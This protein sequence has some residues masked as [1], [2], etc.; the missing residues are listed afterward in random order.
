MIYQR[1]VLFIA[2]Q[3]ISEWSISFLNTSCGGWGVAAGPSF[4]NFC[5]KGVEKF[6]AT[7]LTKRGRRGTKEASEL[8]ANG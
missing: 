3:Q 2:F 5:K 7:V 1:V 8:T 4:L 6:G